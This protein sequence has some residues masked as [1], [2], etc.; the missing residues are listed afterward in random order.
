VGD[1][2]ADDLKNKLL[3]SF[4][5]PK[6][7]ER[8]RKGEVLTDDSSGKSC[9]KKSKSDGSG[10]PLEDYGSSNPKDKAAATKVKIII[11]VII[12]LTKIF[13]PVAMP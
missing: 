3:E 11:F 13:S 6:V 9:S 8:K 1:Y 7:L 2:I 12:I 5:L 10:V 4:G